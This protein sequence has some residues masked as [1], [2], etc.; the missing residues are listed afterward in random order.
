MNYQAN[1]KQKKKFIIAVGS[2]IMAGVLTITG[3]G[4]RKHLKKQPKPVDTTVTT[5]YNNEDFVLLLTE[6]FDINDE[7]AV[8]K[9]VSDI[10]AIL[11][12][13]SEQD[14]K[15]AI[16]MVNGKYDKFVFTSK[17]PYDDIQRVFVMLRDVSGKI[18][19]HSVVAKND[20]EIKNNENKDLTKVGAKEL[21]KQ[22]KLLSMKFE[23]F[24]ISE[25]DL[26]TKL[27]EIIEE[28]NKKDA[29]GNDIYSASDKYIVLRAITSELSFATINNEEIEKVLDLAE[30]DRNTL[31]GII[32]ENVLKLA[33]KEVKENAKDV[34]NKHQDKGDFNKAQTKEETKFVPS[35]K[36]EAEKSP[37]KPT[38][39]DTTK[40]VDQGGK[41]VKPPKKD[42]NPSEKVEVPTTRVE[43]TEE[44]VEPTTKVVIKEEVN[45]KT[46]STT[47]NPDKVIIEYEV[48]KEDE[49]SKKFIEDNAYDITLENGSFSIKHK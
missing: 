25:Q 1:D 48:I 34:A 20:T 46:E 8:N 13:L 26:K 42:N 39:A 40:V 5:E 11:P 44:V 22:V 24:S 18:G 45:D 30:V 4:V 17:N 21:A 41:P 15:N 37:L 6:D 7:A 12:A 49:P 35:D 47:F 36:K 38:E 33:S 19:M 9:R 10:K 28:L 3:F 29:N 31:Q 23:K 16:Y 27:D 2:V 43:V 32:G 14:I